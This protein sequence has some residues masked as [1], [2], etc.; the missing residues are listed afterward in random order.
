MAKLL[1]AYATVE[2]Q[3]RKIARFVADQ[4]TRRRND[5]TLLDLADDATPQVASF[6]AVIVA[7]S[8]HARKHN[9]PAAAFAQANAATLNGLP[10]AFISVSLHA[11]YGD[12]EDEEETRAYVDAF[13]KETGWTP[14]AVHHAAGAFRF[15]EYDFFKRFAAR[16]VA[17]DRG[18]APSKDGDLEFTDWAALTA[19]VDG[20]LRDHVPGA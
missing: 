2:G 20:F 1:V 12:A 7:A 13:V 8:V 10:S 5:V 17:K 14:R 16:A 4:L 18:I 9:A 3:T 6:D 11:V 19:F 15:A